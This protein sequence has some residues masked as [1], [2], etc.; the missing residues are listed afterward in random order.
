MEGRALRAWLMAR[1]LLGVAELRPP[2]CVA[3]AMEM[4]GRPLRALHPCTSKLYFRLADV[5]HAENISCKIHGNGYPRFR[6]ASRVRTHSCVAFNRDAVL[7]SV[8]GSKVPPPAWT[9]RICQLSEFGV[10]RFPK[11][12]EFRLF[13]TSVFQVSSQRF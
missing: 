10:G 6:E 11:K 1:V 8:C 2:M 13:S 4:E 5:S 3:C 9:K 7:N 12:E